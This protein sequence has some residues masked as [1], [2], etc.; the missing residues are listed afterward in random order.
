M[1]LAFSITASAAIEYL[2]LEELRQVK[3]PATVHVVAMTDEPK[4]K[5]GEYLTSKTTWR[6]RIKNQNGTFL[7]VDLYVDM[8]Q[9]KEMSLG[10]RSFVLNHKECD[11]TIE[12]SATG[13]WKDGKIEAV[14]VPLTSADIGPLLLK[15]LGLCAFFAIL[16]LIF[17][18]IHGSGGRSQ[19]RYIEK[20]RLL[21]VNGI[22]YTTHKG[23]I[24]NAILGHMVAGD[25]GA[26]IGAMSSEQRHTDNEFT[27]LVYYN[28]GRK[29]NTKEIEKVR[30]S[31]PRFEILV[32]KLE[33]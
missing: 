30:Q 15:A 18:P 23:I 33:D 5:S 10:E 25:V 3:G 17:F 24:G 11:L 2:S 22:E 20:T 21:A 13:G 7:P 9:Y 8:T 14:H 1:V 32:K 6:W 16:M 12:V 4:G 28:G 27:F 31:N 26:L 29:G 19:D